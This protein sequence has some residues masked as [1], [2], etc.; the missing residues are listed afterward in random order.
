MMSRDPLL[1]ATVGPYLVDALLGEGGMGRVYRVHHARLPQKRYALKVLLGDYAAT[2]PMRARFAKEAHSA[3]RLSHPN[4]VAVCD[5][6]VT[7][8]GLAYLAM[9]LV[10]GPALSELVTN[11]PMAP[12]RVIHLARQ[13]CMGLAHAHDLGLIHR[14]FKPDNI[15]VLDGPAGEVPRIAD[16]GL[17]I[18]NDSQDV[19]LTTGGMVLGT[20]AYVAPEQVTGAEVDHRADLYA[21]GV[22]MF[23]LLSG[24]LLPFDGDAAEV[25]GL[26]ATMAAP[27]LADVAPHANVPL[28]LATIVDR[29]LSRR[30]SERYD[31]ARA[32]A[33]AL[34][35]AV[36]FPDEGIREVAA[37]AEAGRRRAARADDAEIELAR[38]TPA[39]VVAAAPPAASALRI[40]APVVHPPTERVPVHGSSRRRV[41]ILA[42][43]IMLAGI[44]V[45]AT[46]WVTRSTGP[47]SAE[48]ASA[49]PPAP[50]Q[51]PAGPAADPLVAAPGQP[52]VAT[53]APAAPGQSGAAS[54]ASAGPGQSG[55]AALAPAGPSAQEAPDPVTIA[56]PGSKRPGRGRAGKRPAKASAAK[57]PGAAVAPVPTPPAPER[58]VTPPAPP[59]PPAV[60]SAPT[61]PEPTPLP[62]PP[63]APKLA[64]SPRLAT[65]DVHGALPNA[66]V[67]RALDRVLSGAL[68]C[69][70]DRAGAVDVQFRIGESRRAAGLRATGLATSSCLTAALA[71]LRTETAPDVGDVEVRVRFTYDQP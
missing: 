11:E 36:R 34:D 31:D 56:P 59:E 23:E 67:R 69:K 10:E 17:A 14:D 57:E 47:A 22:T 46:V 41:A 60:V 28:A 19:R 26:K 38:A 68:A 35:E 64:L 29:L 43:A 63:P 7:D 16:F 21:L 49:V 3:S 40:E 53:P 44:I 8:A 2:P 20:P 66:T 25:V 54:P 5:F 51:G 4:V 6:G 42:G 37:E 24:G 50:A 61:P 62:A 33:E 70:S 45:G 58:E 15:I 32:V 9:D 65:V 27:K 55:A 1:G 18:T 52:G 48:A 13:L 71:A 12:R 39:P 30:R